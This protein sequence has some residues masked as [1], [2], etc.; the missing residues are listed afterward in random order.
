MKKNLKSILK[1]ISELRDRMKAFV[2]NLPDANSGVKIISKSPKCGVVNFSTIAK[3]NNIL[4]PSYYL[5]TDAKEAIIK[6]LD[7]TPP[8]RLEKV[9]NQIIKEGC[10]RY[11]QTG[12][13]RII[14]NPEFIAEFRKIW[15]A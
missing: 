10:I 5:N 7:R 13:Q 14:L 15:E 4:S 1:T 9:I 2:E 8:D 6:I 12:V 3:N 11:S